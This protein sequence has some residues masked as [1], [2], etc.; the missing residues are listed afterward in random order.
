MVAFPARIDLSLI[1]SQT[2]EQDLSWIE[3]HPWVPL[4]IVLVLMA[5]LILRWVASRIITVVIER[6]TRVQLHPT[7]ART[8]SGRLLLGSA[9]LLH[10]RRNQRLK[11]LGSALTSFSS[12]LIAVIALV[13]I[14]RL[15]D[16]PPLQAWASA[17]VIT[18][19]LAFGAQTLIRDFLTGGFLI[20]EDQYGVGDT[21]DIGSV[22]GTV[23][24]VG[25]RLTQIRDDAG[26][27]WHVRNGE[28]VRVGNKSQGWSTTTVDIP[29][30][31][32]A[33]L[34]TTLTIVTEAVT[35]L[36]NQDE[37]AEIVLAKPEVTGP[38]SLCAQAMVVRISVKTAFGQGVGLAAQLRAT[39][40]DALR[41]NRI[42]LG[43]LAP[44]PSAGSSS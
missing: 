34:S 9:P 28:I 4:T 16:L 30:D 18:A 3:K 41:S 1:A 6:A 32:E 20:V 15:L 44:S 23:E 25:L 36:T 26:V 29:V 37:W 14:V 10:E 38:E 22:S 12:F 19:I 5:A 42:S 31:P 13:V 27:L 39:V 11:T 8:R 35:N 24:A 7:L 43:I 33:D 17:G 21:I 2:G 40:H